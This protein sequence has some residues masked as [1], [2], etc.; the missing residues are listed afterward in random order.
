MGVDRRRAGA[1]T[2]AG[3]A[4]L[5]LVEVQ[6]CEHIRWFAGRVRVG[7]RLA[8]EECRADR[9]VTRA[10]PQVGAST[11]TTDQSM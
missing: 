5:T 3:A 9:T 8:C 2:A 4:L 7:E 1:A 11:P 10:V 6:D